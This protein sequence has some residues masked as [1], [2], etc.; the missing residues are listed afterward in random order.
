MDN[1]N[2]FAIVYHGAILEKMAS[3]C[4]TKTFWLFQNRRYVKQPKC[5]EIS[6][7]AMFG[8]RWAQEWRA[9]KLLNGFK[10]ELEWKQQKNKKP[11]HAP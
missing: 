11:G 4:C 5:K 3:T 10:C 8:W 7:M 9:P 1:D 6:L 2:I